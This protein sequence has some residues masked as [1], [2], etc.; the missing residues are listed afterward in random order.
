MFV[1]EQEEAAY[2]TSERSRVSM[3]APLRYAS[4]HCPELVFI[5]NVNEVVSWGPAGDGSTF[6]WWLK[7]WKKLGYDYRLL[8][9]NS[10]FFPPTPQSRDRLYI[11]CWRKGNTAPNLDFRPTAYCTSE[12]CGGVSVQAVQIWKGDLARGRL[13]EPVGKY[14]GQYGYRCPTCH[15]KVVPLATAAATAID[16]SNLGIRIGDREKPLAANTMDRI[17]R[18]LAKFSGH[19]VVMPVKSVFG[20][21]RVVEEPFCTLT[22]QQDKSLVAPMPSLIYL[23][24][25]PATGGQRPVSEPTHTVT[26]G[27]LHHGLAI[28]SDTLSWIEQYMSQ[29]I[30]VHEQFATIT[31]HSRHALASVSTRDVSEVS[32]AEV[33]NV[34]F[35]M[36]DPD[37]ELRRAMG[38]DD[39]YQ[40]LG[41]KREITAG[42]GNAVTPPVATA[43]AERMFATLSGDME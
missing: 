27:G 1:D 42:L 32:D 29:P 30:Q 21:D 43:I 34:R 18:A 37:P 6:L 38:F 19:S 11:V 23:R 41:T 14:Q 20:S 26:A 22:S 24:G 12:Q 5:E 33:E 3:M 40:L 13:G 7:E 28:P 25:G 9:L 39:D 31:S 36:L 16:W 4:K 15:Q 10:Q 17:R 2:A 8:S 35:R